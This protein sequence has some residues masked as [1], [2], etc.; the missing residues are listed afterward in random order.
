MG[1]CVVEQTWEAEGQRL[2][3]LECIKTALQEGQFT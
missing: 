1:N 3:H 2:K